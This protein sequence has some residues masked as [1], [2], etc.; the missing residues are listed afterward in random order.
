[1]ICKMGIIHHLYKKSSISVISNKY[2]PITIEKLC[3]YRIVFTRQT[4]MTIVIPYRKL[5]FKELEQK[6]DTIQK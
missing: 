2:P 6:F 4:T 1:M 5:I 3:T